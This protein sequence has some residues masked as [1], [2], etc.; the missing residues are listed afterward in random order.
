MN[1]TTK[2][3]V[4]CV[5]LAW[6]A[7][8][9]GVHKLHQRCIL[10]HTCLLISIGLVVVC[11]AFR[12]SMSTWVPPSPPDKLYCEVFVDIKPHERRPP[13]DVYESIHWLLRVNNLNSACQNRSFFYTHRHT[14]MHRGRDRERCKVFHHTYFLL[15]G[16]MLTFCIETFSSIHVLKH[17]DGCLLL[18]SS[19]AC[20]NWLKW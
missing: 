13:G 1:A 4:S 12:R 8:K 5:T 9:Y 20:Q 19:Q 6:H 10:K 17:N 7:S 16:K 11:D 14:H 15:S 2:T 18:V 3:W